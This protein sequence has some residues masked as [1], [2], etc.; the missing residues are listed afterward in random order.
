[1]Y[2]IAKAKPFSNLFI[3]EEALMTKFG[4]SSK[5]LYQKFALGC[6]Q[7]ICICVAIPLL[8]NVT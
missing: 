5:N 8:H 2:N 4:I 1:M 7:Y 3:D 6:V